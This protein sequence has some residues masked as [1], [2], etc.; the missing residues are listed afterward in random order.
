MEIIGKIPSIN[1]FCAAPGFGKSYL[2]KYLIYR[3]GNKLSHGMVFCPT[4]FNGGYDYINKKYIHQ[5]YSDEALRKFMLLQKA[6]V[7]NGTPRDAFLIFD[8]CLGSIKFHGN[9]LIEKLFTSYRHY[10]ITILMSTQYIYR[11]PPVYRECCSNAFIFAQDNERSVKAIY[12]TFM[13]SLKSWKNTYDFITNNTKDFHYIRVQ[14]NPNQPI[15]Y[16]VG[17]AGKT[18][19]FYLDF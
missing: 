18:P 12:E 14:K 19:K 10:R 15:K 3:I 2:I 7:E 13:L 16:A 5:T 4:A 1:L 9:K 8:D 6:L 11:I 17:K